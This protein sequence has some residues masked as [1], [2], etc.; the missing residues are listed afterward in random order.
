MKAL[1]HIAVWFTFSL[2]ALAQSINTGSSQNYS[3][4]EL[5]SRIESTTNWFCSYNPD[6]INDSEILSIPKSL[7]STQAIID[8][9][10][11]YYLFDFVERPNENKL[12]IIKSDQFSIQGLVVDSLTGETI[13]DVL[14][15]SKDNFNAS[16]TN[17]DGYY[18]LSLSATDK[19]IVFQH[20]GYN[21]LVLPIEQLRGKGILIQ[22]SFSSSIPEILILE[23]ESEFNISSN[24]N[25]Y[26]RSQI[27][28]VKGIMGRA[29]VLNY[30][31]TLKSVS[32]GAEGQNGYNVRGGGI[33]QNLILMDGFSVY[34][35]S[36]LGGMSSIF[37]NDAVKK[38]HFYEGGIPSRYGGKLSSALDIRLLDGNRK[39][40]NSKAALGIEGINLHTNGPLSDKTS[41]SISGKLSLFSPLA[42]PILQSNL[43]FIDPELSY[44]D[45]YLKL[46]HW[47][48][49]TN[50]LSLTGYIGNDLV[51]FGRSAVT[52]RAEYIDNNRIEWGNKILG[53]QWHTTLS[54]KVFVKS[55]LGL[56][57]YNFNS[58]GAYQINFNQNNEERST[59][60]FINTQSDLFD[61]VG[62]TELEIY[63][64]NNAHMN[65]GIEYINHSNSPSIFEE[66]NF[67]SQDTTL[68]VIDSTYRSKEWSFFLEN[69]W[70]L[71]QNWKI[72][73]GFRFN[74]FFTGVNAYR[75]F[76][77][78]LSVQYNWTKSSISASYSAMSQF[79]QLLSN[80]GPGL[81][82]DLWVPSTDQ[83][84]PQRSNILD[85]SYWVKSNNI[86]FNSSIFY[87]RFSNL[88]DYTNP[89][90]IIFSLIISNQIFNVQADNQP[91]EE[92]ISIGKG[93]SYGFESSVYY[94][95]NKL[96]SQL[97]YTLSKS[98]R[99]F[100]N[101][102]D[103][104]WFPFKFDRTHDIKFW[105]DYRINSRS[106]FNINF[107]YTTGN[108][109]T[110]TD[111][112][113]GVSPDIFLIPSSRNNARSPSFHHLDILY[114]IMPKKYNGQMSLSIG[115]Y[116][117]YARRNP[118]YIIIQ[119]NVTDNPDE[120]L[121]ETN[122]ISIYPILPQ[123]N[124]SYK[125]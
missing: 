59:A 73:A 99:Q 7:T 16:H 81:P 125:W 61:V 58:Q 84:E 53:G 31:K 43:N 110:F 80:S 109:F 62:G 6:I 117:L 65:V 29:D 48:D 115:I 54:P 50:R 92:R 4:E 102:D 82:S 103:G 98:E 8:Y 69:E 100:D 106:S 118:F 21:K 36:H 97:S 113:V 85:L 90:D 119:Q 96:T 40:W 63:W 107:A 51:K 66:E 114:T 79:I 34:E 19:E 120:V 72:N 86:R 15:Y 1:L 122:K 10:D 25:I 111:T 41:I 89:T 56:T 78:R 70:R 13:P 74:Q 28:H 57:Q 20:L 77:P 45:A 49:D 75:H 116:N 9:V 22:L 55:K 93:R 88:I 27:D 123:F 23:S 37:M 47:I 32:A 11:Q 39:S 124:I 38:V 105:I 87:K 14:I 121:L 101:I 35:A 108:A 26:N 83:L 71:K 104:A 12:L 68:S 17:V 33:D 67:Y 2:P 52:A 18:R 112:K 94:E 24:D 30:I 44:G 3:I 60:F 76:N 95:K 5:I 46:T 91:W 64:N 42:S